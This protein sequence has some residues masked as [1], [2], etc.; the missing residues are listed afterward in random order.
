MKRIT[1][2]ISSLLLLATTAFTGYAKG[3]VELTTAVRDVRIA[4]SSK[5][6]TISWGDG[7]TDSYE[8]TDKTEIRH[9]YADNHSHTI[10]INADSLTILRC[11]YNQLTAL[12]VRWN[13]ALIELECSD[14]QLHALDVRR[15]TALTKLNCENNSLGVLNVSQNTAL[16]TLIC[17]NNQ[18]TEL[19][20]R[21]N[22]ALMWLSCG[23][24]SL[25]ALDVSRNMALTKL[26]CEN[27]QLSVLDVSRNT[28]LK[29]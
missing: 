21:W 17:R 5:A 4:T 9:A 24:N 25:T 6:M 12:E 27:I 19:D 23:D 28:D 15:N 26:W 18:L 11:G 13:T 29:E 8:S 1:L 14:N 20:V 10:R 2:F 3:I 7:K 16:Q 22:T